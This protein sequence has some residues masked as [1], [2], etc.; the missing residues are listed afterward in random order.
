MHIAIEGMDGV[1]KTTVAN[2]LA[3]KLNFTIVEKPLHLLFDQN[4]SFTNYIKYRDYV[5]LQ[6]DNDPLRA[7]FYG[8]GNIFLDRSLVFRRAFAVLVHA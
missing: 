7:W 1:G 3:K 5:N 6:V 2:I 4:D 8:L